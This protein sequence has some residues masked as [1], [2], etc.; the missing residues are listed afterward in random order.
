MDTEEFVN[1]L[2]DV[3]VNNSNLEAEDG[4]TVLFN[5]IKSVS[6]DG[7]NGLS[8]SFANGRTLVVSVSVG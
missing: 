6:M 2:M 8:V 7:N 3:I 5:K 1:S 4:D